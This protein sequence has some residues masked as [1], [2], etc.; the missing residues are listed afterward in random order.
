MTKK[1]K[2]TSYLARKC[3]CNVFYESKNPRCSGPWS[4]FSNFVDSMMYLNTKDDIS[5]PEK[6]I[7]WFI[8]IY[9]GSKYLTTSI[10]VVFPNDNTEIETGNFLMVL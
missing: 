9:Q 1:K 4:D 2:V 6:M 5:Y 3:Q 7:G 8:E 10:I